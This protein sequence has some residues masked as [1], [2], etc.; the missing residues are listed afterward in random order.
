VKSG[1][2]HTTFVFAAP[3]KEP[4]DGLKNDIATQPIPV[5][6][7]KMENGEIVFLQTEYTKEYIAK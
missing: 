5:L 3:S 4:Q 2:I 7:A 6:L 1:I